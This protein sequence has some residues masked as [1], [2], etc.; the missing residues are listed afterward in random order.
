MVQDYSRRGFLTVLA[1]ASAVPAWAAPPEIS[2]RPHT[3]PSGL[4]KQA[5]PAAEALIHKA[6]LSGQI[7]FAV[8][9]TATGR[10][11]ESHGGAQGLPPA[12][13]TKS[14][15]ALYALEK[16]G[17]SHRFRT[18][19]ITTGPV[20]NGILK[21]DLVLAGGGDPTLDTDALADMARKLKAAGVREVRGQFQVW[22]GALPYIGKIDNNQPDHVG[23]NPSISGLALNFNRV[24]FE[25][26]RSGQGWGV[27]MDARSAKYRPEVA[28]AKMAVQTRQLPVYTYESRGGTDHWTVA[29]GALGNGGSRWLPVRRPD[30]YAG[31][32]FRTLARA[33]GISLPKETIANTL[34]AGSTVVTQQSAVLR[35]IL[36]LTLKYSTNLSAEMIGLAATQAD[37]SKA[38]SL[39]ASGQAMTRWARDKLDMGQARFVDHSG[40]GDASRVTAADMVGA[41]DTVVARQQLKPLLKPV[42]LRH[43]NGKPNTNHPLKVVAK[44]G[45]LNFASTLAGYVTATDGSELAFAIFT[46][47]QSKRS[48]LGKDDR[49]RPKGSRSWIRKSKGLQQ[50]LLERWGTLYSA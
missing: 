44:T 8:A 47:D 14:I 18:R 43:A 13:V 39:L 10:V 3:R 9:D 27:S 45:T 22:A 28:I 2:L 11:L 42:I 33:H 35:D 38:T 32:V 5:I 30:K 7:G 31:D 1:A 24:H 23:Y 26:R 50:T 48:K 17:P 25:W 34:P 4:H 20:E 46:A 29:S 41:L 12:S 6:G 21:G 19:L 15:T 36:R 40:L 49:E 37:G 16:L